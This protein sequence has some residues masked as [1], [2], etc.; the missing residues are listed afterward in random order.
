[1][2]SGSDLISHNDQHDM[3]R[4]PLGHWTYGRV[5]DSLGSDGAPFR[6]DSDSSIRILTSHREHR[7]I[8]L[9]VEVPRLQHDAKEGVNEFVWPSLSSYQ[10]SVSRER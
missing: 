8:R 4:F 3:C 5:K 10:L 6:C 1:M 9:Q 7:C 2:P